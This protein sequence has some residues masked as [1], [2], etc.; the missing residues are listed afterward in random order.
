MKKI[1]FRLVIVLVVLVVV[2]LTALYFSLNGIVKKGV[3]RVGPPMTKT[4]VRLDSAALS[5]FS[6]SGKLSGLL[7]GNPQGYTNTPFAV[8]FGSVAVAVKIGSVFSDTVMVDSIDI[9]QPEICLEGSLAGNNLSQILANL[10]GT[11]TA[12]AAQPSAPAPAQGTSKKF[13]VKDLVLNG[14]KLRANVTALDKHLDEEITL[15]NIHLTN[16]GT[17]D[18]GASP[19]ELCRQ[20]LEPILADAVKSAGDELAK[21]GVETLQKQGTD[22]VNKA[23]Q[24]GLDKLLKK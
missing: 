15:P 13:I 10:K 21:K 2:G 17:A 12:P 4:D 1:F 18:G 6:G 7:V 22:A 9:E 23:V 3:E 24:G 11:N 19:A 5:P 8:Q 14:A 20:L 16:I